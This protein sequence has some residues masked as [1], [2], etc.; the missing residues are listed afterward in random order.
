MDVIYKIL[1]AITAIIIVFLFVGCVRKEI[2]YVPQIVEKEVY[3]PYVPD[4]P[5]IECKFVGNDTEVM[6]QMIE[7]IVAHRKLYDSLKLNS[8][9]FM[10]E[11]KSNVQLNTK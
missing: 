1:L 3:L 4:L 10:L 9:K 11:G 6:K 8:N 5:E 2:E 7:C